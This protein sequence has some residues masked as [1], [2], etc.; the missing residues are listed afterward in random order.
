MSGL[1][2]TPEA[3][4]DLA[5]RIVATSAEYLESLDSRPTIPPVSGAETTEHFDVPLPEDGVGNAILDDLVRI[6]DACRAGTGR[7]VP[8]VVGCG[9]PVAAAADLFASVL[10]QNVTAWRSAPA[11]ASRGWPA[12]TRSRSTRTSGCTSRST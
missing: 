7:L 3:F 2:V 5:A 11:A 9:E 4:R 8:Y 6:A 10:N 1:T 12:R